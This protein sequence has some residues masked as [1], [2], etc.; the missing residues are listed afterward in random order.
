MR[1]RGQGTAVERVSLLN[2]IRPLA[3][4]GGKLHREGE[5]HGFRAPRRSGAAGCARR[6]VEFAGRPRSH[7]SWPTEPLPHKPDCHR[8]A[9]CRGTL[10][11]PLRNKPPTFICTSPRAAARPRADL[12]HGVLSFLG[13]HLSL[14]C[15]TQEHPAQAVSPPVR[16]RRRGGRASWRSHNLIVSFT[17]YPETPGFEV[18]GHLGGDWVCWHLALVRPPGGGLLECMANCWYPE[19]ANDPLECT[20]LPA[21]EPGE[22]STT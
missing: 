6:S 7:G 8:M 10:G 11:R 21:A 3:V 9:R 22:T 14:G 19:A 18:L 17:D 20:A 13:L 2:R 5:L 4:V 16:R 15:S 12:L 1:F